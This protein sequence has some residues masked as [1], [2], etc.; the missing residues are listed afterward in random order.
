[1][2]KT[3]LLFAMLMSF[4]MSA[5]AQIVFQENFDA[6]A[7]GALPT[8]W[9]RFNVDGL[10]PYTSLSWVTDAWVCKLYGGITTKAAWSTSYYTPVGTANDW[11]FTPA[12][13]VPSSYPVL[14][15]TELAQDPSYPDGYELRIS[16]VAPTAANLMN[17]TVIST[18]TAASNPAAIKT[19][20][21]SAY[22]GQTVYIGWRN[23]SNDKFTLGIDDVVVKSLPA[24]GAS[25]LSST[26]P[27]YVQVSTPITVAGVL[28]NTGGLAITALNLNYSINGGAA[29]TQ[30]LT[31]L[32]ILSLT[33]YNFSHSTI[34]TPSSIAGAYTVKIW[35][36]SING[37]ATLLSDTLT[38]IVNTL[39]TLV[40]R[41]VVLEEYTGIHCQYCPDGHKRANDYKAMHPNDVFLINI[42]EG[43]YAVPAAGE[44]DFRTA[45]G[46]ALSQQTALAGYPSGTINRHVFSPYTTTALNRGEWAANGN[47]ILTMP[48]YVTLGITA[49]VNASTRLLTV[50]TTGNYLAN[51]PA[52]NMMNVAL[53]Q[54]NVLGP[55][56][57]GITWNPTQVLPDGVTYIH[58]HMLRH[59]ITGQWGDSI[60]VTTS[61]TNRVK[62]YTYTL[63]ATING[64][65]LD[66]YN[67]E[68]VAFI[69]EGN[70]EIVTGAEYLLPA[71]VQE[72]NNGVDFNV[73][74]N[75][76]SDNMQ[77]NFNLNE[78]KKVEIKIYNNLGAIVFT[79]N[80][81]QLI[82][83]NH[84]LE[85]SVSDLAKGIYYMN[86]KAGENTIS[87]KIV[88]Q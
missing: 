80:E 76:A 77:I 50:N 19:I 68:V 5:N 10:T 23:N 39:T 83:G 15:F 78:T 84:T 21:L 11:M 82:S 79:S 75:P 41:K 2:K 60:L 32:N 18:V 49:S 86:L 59:L 25:M 17:S 70:Q 29:V 13:L 42:H 3:S 63:P 87:K 54:N 31:G 72:V 8:S 14:Q 40:Y 55:Q 58:G 73:Y 22:A 48:T 64:V 71:S 52:L 74:P 16:T 51:G 45:F 53:V 46:T 67:I 24:N 28:T 37:N 88:I 4:L 27:G 30:N 38:K 36:S 57:A 85:I 7:D 69:S 33:N 26:L 62:T 12:I 34:W 47:I 20:N 66:I 56:T 65:N 44:P 61:G 6:I 35:A 1:M 9:T 81:G 43:S